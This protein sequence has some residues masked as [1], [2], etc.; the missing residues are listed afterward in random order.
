M[1][2]RPIGDYE[3]KESRLFLFLVALATWRPLI[4]HTASS[5]IL[6]VLRNTNLFK[7]YIVL[8]QL[9]RIT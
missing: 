8:G 2:G 7:G 1:E 6:K 3:G 5:V 4:S 9:C